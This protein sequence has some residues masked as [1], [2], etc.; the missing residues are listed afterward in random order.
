MP[1][2][3]AKRLGRIPGV[4]QFLGDLQQSTTA[5][6]AGLGSRVRG[7]PLL[8]EQTDHLLSAHV[9]RAKRVGEGIDVQKIAIGDLACRRGEEK[10]SPD[11]AGI[12]HRKVRRRAAC[13][14]RIG[15]HIAHR[16]F[17]GFI[18]AQHRVVVQQA[19]LD[20]GRDAADD[21]VLERRGE[22]DVFGHQRIHVGILG[23]LGEACRQCSRRGVLDHRPILGGLGLHAFGRDHCQIDVCRDRAV[24]G[25]LRQQ[26]AFVAAVVFL[27]RMAA[28]HDIH[29]SA[30]LIQYR[31]DVARQARAGLV[32]QCAGGGLS[33]LMNQH[34]DRIHAF[35]LEFGSAGV[36]D[37]RLLEEGQADDT[38]RAD[39]GWRV[40]QG[41]TD[42]SDPDDAEVLDEGR[43]QQRRAGL[44]GRNVCGQPFELCA[45]KRVVLQA[46]VCSGRA[47][48]KAAAVLEAKQFSFSGIELVVAD[49]GDLQPERVEHIHGGFVVQ[50]RRGEGGG[51]DQIASTDNDVVGVLGLEGL[52]HRSEIGRTAD[53]DLGS[54]GIARIRNRDLPTVGRS[55]RLDVSVK[56]VQRDQLDRHRDRGKRIQQLVVSVANRQR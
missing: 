34:H 40:L 16:A 13:Q 29:I 6:D 5:V 21:L 20:V 25:S 11:T 48:G 30:G 37:R 8:L 42:E 4:G 49:R 47:T 12:G 31:K 50:H 54:G 41:Q 38:A 46:G 9:D 10:V 18:P 35:A 24:E 17:A 53:V 19:T 3:R 56:V 7:L 52:D 27:V 33:A 45:R 32:V 55:R 43:R 44:I 15:Q 23:Q 28:D 14:I 22:R 51:A 1:R 2:R 36:D 26:F 39:C